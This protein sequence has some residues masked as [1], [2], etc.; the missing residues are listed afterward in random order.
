MNQKNI[1]VAFFCLGLF[2]AEPLSDA[3]HTALFNPYYLLSSPDFRL[4]ILMVLERFR[5]PLNGFDDL[6]ILL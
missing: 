3:L 5:Y 2:R 6:K 1:C 4:Q